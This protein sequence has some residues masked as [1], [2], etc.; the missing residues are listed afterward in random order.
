MNSELTLEHW[1]EALAHLRHLSAEVNRTFY[2]WIG[3]NLVF[4]LVLAIAPSV[5]FLACGRSACGTRLLTAG[6]F[7]FTLAGRYLFRRARI[8]YLQMLAKKT[9]IEDDLGFYERLF[10][11]GGQTD[12]AFPWRL[13]PDAIAKIQADF[14]GWVTF[15]IRS[16]GTMARIQ[17]FCLDAFLLVYLLMF[18]ATFACRFCRL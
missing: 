7:L 5:H 16:K 8:Y 6:G 2:F 4:V 11:E 17:F 13:A 14:E 10:P 9:L 3:S 18:A 15:S 1:R 12:L